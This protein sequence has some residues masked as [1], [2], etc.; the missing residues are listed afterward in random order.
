MAIISLFA[1]LCLLSNGTFM[2]LVCKIYCQMAAVEKTRGECLLH[3]PLGV[4]APRGAI[5]PYTWLYK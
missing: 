5:T 3:G 1:G 2:I 4:I